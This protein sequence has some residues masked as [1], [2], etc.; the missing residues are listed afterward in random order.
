VVLTEMLPGHA[1]ALLGRV[2]DDKYRIEEIIGRGGMGRVYRARHVGTGRPVAVK[3]I[4]EGLVESPEADARFRREAQAA[5]SIRHPNVVDV[6]DFGVAHVGSIPKLA[7]LVMEYLEGRTLKQLL[8]DEKRIPLAAV[9]DIVEQVALALEQAHRRSIVH[10]DLK[11]DNIWLVPDARGGFVVKVLDFGVAALLGLE[12]D[13]S[14]S[15][16]SGGASGQPNADG[17]AGTLTPP[18]DPGTAPTL[19]GSEPGTLGAT[20]SAPTADVLAG[21]EAAAR[22]TMRGSAIGTPAYM[23][24][25]QWRG[26][27]VDARSDLYSLGLVTFE[28]L[29]GRR[30]FEGT[31]EEVERKHIAEVAP[32]ADAA[33]PEVPA[34]VA[35]V[36]GRAL[37]K[38]PGARHPSAAA[39]AGSLRVAAEG[40]TVTLRRALSLYSDRLDQLFPIIARACLPLAPWAVLLLVAALF[41]LAIPMHH[42]GD[43]SVFLIQQVVAVTLFALPAILLWMVITFWSH[44][45][46]AFVVDELRARPIGAL[47]YDAVAER[48]E[49]R[50]G[51][52][53]S[54]GFWAKTVR[55]AAFYTRCESHA[56]LGTG[57]VAFLVAALEGGNPKEGG[58]RCRLLAPAVGRTYQW[59]RLSI[60]VGVFLP[61]CLETALVYSLLRAA[62]LSTLESFPLLLL[63][64]LIPLNALWTMPVFSIAL[65]LLYFRSRQGAGEDVSL[66]S[67]VTSRL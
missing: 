62:G 46:F 29:T 40:P 47:R 15:A 21:E 36:I 22:L 33:D 57:D 51:A 19:S 35:D 3:V 18:T 45:L 7:Y 32:R 25:E 53:P 52:P 9:L 44:S 1:D 27:P 37:S 11:P 16:A 49:K 60:F 10:R 63:E 55:L 6:T 12:I 56:P 24:P 59:V 2:L 28:M 50:I 67:V 41:T 48:L 42:T 30:A 13:R 31:F 54:A 39:F 5:G 26:E 34:K 14:Q 64:A 38:D 65:A 43:R 58:A 61:P 66:G 8:A 23:S 17:G 4:L 20:S